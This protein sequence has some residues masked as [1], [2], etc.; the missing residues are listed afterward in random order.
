MHP[1]I[2]KIGTSMLRCDAWSKVT[3]KEKYSADFYEGNFLWAGLKR[4][5]VAHARIKRI[6][7]ETARRQSGIVA[8]LTFRDV[9]GSNRQGIVKKDQPVLVE[10]RV[11]RIGDPVAMVLAETRTALSEALNA[12]N[13]EWDPLPAVFDANAALSGDPLIHA[14]SSGNILAAVHVEKGEG[15]SALSDCKTV[16]SGRF[17]LPR[18]EHAY[19]ETEAG[20]AQMDADGKITITV[21]TQSPHRDRK[22]V[23]EALG[24]PVERIRVI[25]PYLGGGFGGKD[26]ATVQAL[27]ALAALHANRRPVKMWW[28]REE[29]FLYS[30]KRMPAEIICRIGASEDGLLQAMDC[31]ILM[32]AGAYDHLCGE[33]LA[34]AVEHAGGVYRIPHV[35]IDGKSVYTNNPPSGPFR[36]FGV[37]Q[38]T[39]VIEQLVDMLAERL[40]QDPLELRIKNVLHQGDQ[41]PVGVTMMHSTGA[42]A[43]LNHLRAH[44]LWQER[45]A[46]KQSAGAFK[47]RGVGIALLSHGLGYGPIIPD[48]GNAKIE[49]TSEGTFK[50][51]ASVSDMGQGNAS[52][53]LQIAADLFNQPPE[54]LELVLPDTDKTLPS[55]SSAASRTTYT[56]A[57][58]LIGAAAKLK[59]RLFEKSASRLGVNSTDAFEML[60]GKI[61][62]LPSGREIMLSSLADGLSDSERTAVHSWQAPVA[63]EKVR[64]E[65][66][67]VFGFPHIVFSYAAHLAAVEVDLL[68]GAIVICR[69]LAM[70]D[71]GRILNPQLFEQQIHGGIAQG[72]GYGLYEDYR[73][74]N[75]CSRT[76]NLT[77]YILPTAMDVP[78]MDSC[79]LPLFEKTGPF[80]MKGIGEIPIS[81]PLPAIANALAD[82][83]GIRIF[84]PPM[85]PEKVLSALAE[86]QNDKDQKT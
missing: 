14:E 17:V 63:T 78:E 50:I 67:S 1:E 61:R 44:T 23:A 19:L 32:D 39:A 54:R 5:D 4:S 12:I 79:A 76:P 31:R 77:T 46:W 45:A 16:V 9:P 3:G 55:G 28:D 75:G 7:T 15:E 40:G 24:L 10:E 73:V 34:L 36:G 71:G 21:S 22:E 84:Q 20:F 57:N 30:V 26:G 33:I 48:I 85:T 60:P 25:A 59:E 11:R 42:I 53:F 29:S 52:T 65:L 49:L 56:Y 66:K 58:A 6:H 74:E 69:Y 83:C 80:G 37:P 38:I 35:A 70:T 72:I 43:C 62:H 27:L 2:P 47:R 86:K 68:T 18:Q 41:N 51:D 8:V 82:A 13:V 81:G 64:A